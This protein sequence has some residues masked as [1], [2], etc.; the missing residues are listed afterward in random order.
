V[1]LGPIWQGSLSF[2]GTVLEVD[3]TDPLLTILHPWY[4]PVLDATGRAVRYLGGN[5]T[6]P[7]LP[8]ALGQAIGTEYVLLDP[9]LNVSGSTGAQWMIIVPF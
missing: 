4:V 9:Q 7:A 3:P 2:G 8:N 1:N 6:L 5:V